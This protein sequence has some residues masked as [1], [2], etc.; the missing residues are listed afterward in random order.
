MLHM[1]LPQRK[2]KIL[3]LMQPFQNYYQLVNSIAT[4]RLLCSA[5]K[6]VHILT[7]HLF[8]FLEI[9]LLLNVPLPGGRTCT[10]WEPSEPE[11]F[12]SLP[13]IQSPPQKRSVLSLFML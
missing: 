13:K 5:G 4:T 3:G 1:K 7:L 2:V 6:E 11:Q 10:A 8:H 9:Y 12:L